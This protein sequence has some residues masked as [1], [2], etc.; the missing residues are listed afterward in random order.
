MIS[1]KPAVQ[2]Q[3]NRGVALLHSFAYSAAESAFQGVAEQ[4][5][6][7]AMA[8]WGI[9]MTHFHQLWE[10][11]ISPATMSLAQQE[12][13]Q[14]QQIGTS[15]KRERQF[16]NA[17]GLIYQDAAT[18]PYRTRALNYEQAMSRLAAKNRK[19][20]EAQVFYALA[21]LATA[22]PTDKTH[23][24]QKQA[25]D[26][27]EPLYSAYPRHPGIPHY[28]IHACDNA[29]MALKGLPAARAY[30]KIAPSAP[31][32]LHM[33]SHIFTRLGLWQDSITS[34]LAAK[35][36]AQQQG[37][38]GE[39]LHA[40]DY[41]VYAY[42]QSGWDS[43]AL[44]VIQQLRKMPELNAGNFK[45][46]YAATAMPVRYAVERG[47][48]ADAAGIL[49]PAA[50]PPH[51]VAIAV[52]ARGVGLARSGRATEPGAEVDKL[53]QIE[54]QLRRSGNDY[55]A[56]QTVILRREVMAWSAQA[57][58]KPEEA[59]A[60]MRQ[61]ADEED[62][63]EKLPVTPG[64]IVPAREQLG[65]LLLEQNRP[66]LAFKEFQTALVN[67]PGRR[68]ALQ[69]AARAAELSRQNQPSP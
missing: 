1:C 27:L 50:A 47:Q 16:I 60:L 36:A 45:I 11:P 42:L 48:W 15:S 63:I 21:L 46:G 13:Q 53:G 54:Q 51:V 29:E 26:L 49:P 9:A 55:W 62:A 32:A 4:D 24:K 67:A 7:C 35:D 56:T 64:P 34:N 22:S 31:H 28:L 12:I 23:A 18:V 10:P 59:V 69:G 41:L 8:H 40:M 39:E 58:R 68:G 61:A 20:T 6:G 14:A 65:D 2:Q 57:D 30:A 33:P 38:T 37:D 17:L 3:F 19:D 5:H 44:E 66:V 25:A 52:W 43:A